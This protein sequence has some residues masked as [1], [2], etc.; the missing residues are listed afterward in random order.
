[1]ITIPTLFSRCLV[2]AALVGT[3]FGHAFAQSPATGVI[4]GRV[5]DAGT[6]N[7]VQNVR[8]TVG[9][10]TLEAVT[11]AAGEYRLANAPAGTMNLT[12]RLPNFVSQTR[13]V[14]VTAGA[15]VRQDYDLR[16]VGAE[17][18][19]NGSVL[20][21][22][23]FTVSGRVMGAASA[24]LADQHNS[25]ILK[26]VVAFEE[27]GDISGD[28]N[29]GEFLKYVPGVNMNYG[30]DIAQ[31]A[32]V[33]GVPPNGTM[34]MLDGA[35]IGSSTGDRQFEITGAS[36]GNIDRIEI[37]KTPTPD[38]S[39]NSIGGAINIVGKSGFSRDRPLFSYALYENFNIM[40]GRP[41]LQPH[42]G[43]RPS[44]D[45]NRT[46][47]L[48]RAA[49]IRSLRHCTG[50]QNVR[51]H[52]QCRREQPVSQLRCGE[53]HLGSGQQIPHRLRETGCDHPF[54]SHSYRRF[55]GLAS[56]A[57]RY[58]PMCPS[59]VPARIFTWHSPV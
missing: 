53:H 56:R 32:S 1:M 37:T 16:G 12:A 50:Q 35:P 55:G 17:A 27:F 57:K 54:Q 41:G 39:A 33:R 45:A 29:P 34:V 47:A 18:E 46:T 19:A 2:L 7:F 15:T 30:P 36:T 44:P 22:D 25:G 9:D 49:R 52:A 42:L 5:R 13:A 10:S 40:N 8:I 59:T 58:R 21:L 6:N 3:M 26:N 4:E 38:M 23:T 28:G 43:K 20:Q 14:T 11:N 51:V 31:F 24:A 48:D